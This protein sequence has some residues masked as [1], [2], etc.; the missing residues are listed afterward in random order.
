VSGIHARQ[1]YKER[2]RECVY[3]CVGGRECVYVCVGVRECEPYMC[4]RR[5]KRQRCAALAF[6]L[7]V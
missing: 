5:I 7:C 4:D 2:A 3:V 1:K 6:L